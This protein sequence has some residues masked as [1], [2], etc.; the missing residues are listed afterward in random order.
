MTPH[1]AQPDAGSAFNIPSGRKGTVLRLFGLVAMVCVLLTANVAA[2]AQ[3]MDVSFSDVKLRE[4]GFPEV[5]ITV[6]PDGVDA[7]S[8]LA[9]GYYLISL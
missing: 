9:A 7:P 6:G 5:V 4:L 2:A 3:E 8:E 1:T